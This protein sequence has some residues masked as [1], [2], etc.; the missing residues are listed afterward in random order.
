MATYAS[1][2]VK[3]GDPGIVMV[4]GNFDGSAAQAD[5]YTTLGAGWSV[6]APNTGLY[7]ITLDRDYNSLLGASFV[8]CLA[9]ANSLTV[10]LIAGL[11]SNNQVRIRV[12]DESNTLTDLT[13]SDK[14]YFI[15]TLKTGRV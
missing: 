1:F 9:S 6:T 3:A 12:I 4:S 11:E 15:L 10:Q 5:G 7:T 8:P 2:T 13:G 14:I